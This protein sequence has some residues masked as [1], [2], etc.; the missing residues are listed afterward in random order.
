MRM[1]FQVP[2][3][4]WVSDPVVVAQRNTRS[5]KR[6]KERSGYVSDVV[7]AGFDSLIISSND[8][9][10]WNVGE[11]QEGGVWRVNKPLGHSACKEFEYVGT[12][13]R[14]GRGHS[15]PQGTRLKQ[16]GLG[17]EE[18]DQECYKVATETF[19][20]RDAAA[21]ERVVMKQGSA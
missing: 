19:G 6:G 1:R 14:S 2:E 15:H 13:M 10:C 11:V 8:G 20:R 7:V 3:K 21:Q 4:P 5:M 16:T 9:T 18:P 17:C 12:S